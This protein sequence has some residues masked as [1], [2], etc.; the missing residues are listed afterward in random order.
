[1][2]REDLTSE[3]G[4]I[5]V[6]FSLLCFGS[7]Q[8]PPWG[9]T[10]PTLVLTRQLEERSSVARLCSASALRAEPMSWVFKPARLLPTSSHSTQEQTWA[11]NTCSVQLWGC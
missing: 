10:I 4:Y 2:V 3:P 6:A 7:Q 5:W 8:L 1:M 11:G 9:Q